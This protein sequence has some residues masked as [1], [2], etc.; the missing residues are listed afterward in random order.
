MC[1]GGCCCIISLPL[2]FDF[3][4]LILPLGLNFL[5][6]LSALPFRIIILLLAF[7]FDAI[8]LLLAFDFDVIILLL[9]FDSLARVSNLLLLC[10]ADGATQRG[11]FQHYRCASLLYV[12]DAATSV[13][14]HLAIGFRFF[15]RL[16]FRSFF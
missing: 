1:A 15:S 4:V 3:L 11:Q 12:F 5:A 7:D 9:D 10:R 2:A 14:A 16:P 8:I 13:I 6:G